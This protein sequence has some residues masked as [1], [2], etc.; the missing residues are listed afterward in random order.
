MSWSDMASFPKWIV[1][2]FVLACVGFGAALTSS[3]PE[4]IIIPILFFFGLVCCGLI[5]AI[6]FWAG[7]VI[8]GAEGAE[9]AATEVRERVLAGEGEVG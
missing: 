9:K 5:I 2:V 1:V 4:R 3:L 7:D 8:V 6:Q